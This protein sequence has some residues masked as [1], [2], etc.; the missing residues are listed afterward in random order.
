[1]EKHYEY[2]KDLHMVFVDYKQAYDSVNRE[3]LWEVLKTFGIPLK[4]I[5]MV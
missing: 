2:A 3:K 1:M 4:I 5:K